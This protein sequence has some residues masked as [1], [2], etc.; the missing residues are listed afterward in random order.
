MLQLIS[1]AK[2]N[3][4]LRILGKRPDGYHEIATLMQAI[5]LCDT[6]HISFDE[7]DSLTCTDPRLPTDGTNLILKA[8]ELY[9]NKTGFNRYVKVHLIKRIPLEAGMG[10]GSSNA[11]TLLWAFNE[12]CGRQASIEDLIAWS[13]EIGSDIPFFFSRGTAYCTGRGEKIHPLPPLPFQQLWIVKPAQGLSSKEVYTHL[14][15]GSLENRDPEKALKNFFTGHSLY[16]NDLE[17]SAFTLAPDLTV[18]R[19]NLIQQGLHDV[20]MS[21]SGTSFFCFGENPPSVSPDFFVQK[22]HYITRSVEKW[23]ERHT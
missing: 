18:L 17:S 13:S 19:K 23:Y 21:G 16:F 4:F 1:P 2:V 5:D 9:R 10:G 15:A 12:L 7:Q 8:A 20:V 3:L 11:A 6:L 14:K 22:A